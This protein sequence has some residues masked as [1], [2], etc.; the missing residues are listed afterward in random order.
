MILPMMNK[1]KLP[2]RGRVR[3]PRTL[4]FF[5]SAFGRL[6]LIILLAATPFGTLEFLLPLYAR[7]L[8]GTPTLIG[9]LV[10]MGA[11]IGVAVRPLAGWLADRGRAPLLL[12]IGGLGLVIGLACW[13]VADS[14]LVLILGRLAVSVGLACLGLAAQV[15]V[16]MLSHSNERGRA[17]GRITAASALGHIVGAIIAGLVLVLWDGETQREAASLLLALN[18]RVALPQVMER[19]SALHLVFGAY[20]VC[21]IAALGLML[22][23]WQAPAPAL[24]R[25]GLWRTWTNLAGQR[26]LR[27]VIGVGFLISVGYSLSVPMILPLLQDRFNAGLGGLAVTYAIPGILYSLAPAA[28]GQ[29]ADRWGYQRAASLGLLVSASVYGLLPVLPALGWTAV[30]WCAEALAYSLYVP[31]MQAMLTAAAPEHQRGA[32]FSLYSIVAAI[33][34]VVGAPLGGALYQ[35]LAP[36]V[37]FGLSTLALFAASMTIRQRRV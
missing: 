34:A 9:V 8:G 22:Q 37:P 31:A 26:S 3:T 6:L 32:A 24:T 33:G 25:T 29:R 17:F 27:T 19:I 20:A 16:G 10:G 13:T 2:T 11:A 7:T 30:V 35:H 23:R 1:D 21:A 28:L 18:L 15:L 5:S 14:V 36:M 4:R 12:Q